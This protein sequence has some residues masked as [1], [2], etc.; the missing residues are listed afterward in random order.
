[1][2]KIYFA[3]SIRAGR[4]D[5]ETYNEIIKHLQKY[6]KVLTEHIGDGKIKDSGEKD[7]SE[8]YVFERDI[9]WLESA[10]VLIA[11]ITTPSLG[12]GFEIARAVDLNKKVLC[13]YKIQ[14]NKKLSAMI[15]GCPD[16]T[17]RGYSTLE[18][19]FDFIKE[20]LSY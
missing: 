3:G 14:D 6:G 17:V 4:N 7:I 20:F 12:V 19:A 5:V 15:L 2:K 8:K 13:L 9:R 16:I 11:E 1:M 18:E 10:D